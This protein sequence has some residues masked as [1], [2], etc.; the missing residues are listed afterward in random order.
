MQCKPLCRGLILGASVAFITACGSDNDVTV[1]EV[2]PPEPTPVP[3]SYDVTVTN[4]TNAQPLSPI[5][6][7]LHDS[8]SLWAVGEAATVALETMA[9]SGDNSQ[10]LADSRVLASTSG[11]GIVAAGASETIVVTIND[12]TMNYLSV[13]TM[14]VNTNDAFTGLT[15]YDLSM[16]NVGD[17][18]T[19]SMPIWDAGTEANTEE[20]MTIPGPAGNGEGFNASREIRDTVAYHPGVVSSDDGLTTSALDVSHKFDNPGVRI[21]ITRTE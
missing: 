20:A 21:L 10:L 15:N 17:S 2:P 3:T 7:M 5:A 8:A 6:V 11:M 4:L 14:L 18:V 19:L 1:V 16:L 12:R 9:E 13:T